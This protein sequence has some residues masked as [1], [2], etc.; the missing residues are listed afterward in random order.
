[1]RDVRCKEHSH[2]LHHLGPSISTL[3]AHSKQY[4]ALNTWAPTHIFFLQ[5]KERSTARPSHESI[6]VSGPQVS[7]WAPQ[8]HST[9]KGPCECGGLWS[10]S[11]NLHFCGGHDQQSGEKGISSLPVDGS[12]VKQLHAR[13]YCCMRSSLRMKPQ[14]VHITD[15]I[16]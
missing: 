16:L 5:R 2:A 4:S 3:A 1:M 14:F 11:G 7:P 10:K 9:A 12:I 8:T 6:C 13:R 15:D